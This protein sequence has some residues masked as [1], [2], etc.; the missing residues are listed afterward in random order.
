MSFKDFSS[1]QKKPANDVLDAKL[2]EAPMV[3][4]PP[5]PPEKAPAIVTPAS[6]S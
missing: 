1:A 5:A 2:S 4:Q 6:K 3:D